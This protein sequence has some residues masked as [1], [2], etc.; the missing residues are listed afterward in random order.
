MDAD[1]AESLLR[2]QIEKYPDVRKSPNSCPLAVTQ[3]WCWVIARRQ[4][5]VWETLE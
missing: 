1:H 5:S 2:P 3:H 4:P